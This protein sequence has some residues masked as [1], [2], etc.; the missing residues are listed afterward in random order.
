MHNFTNCSSISSPHAH[1][2]RWCCRNPN[3][4]CS[5]WLFNNHPHRPVE[6]KW[7]SDSNQ[8]TSDW[9]ESLH[10]TT[11]CFPSSLSLPPHLRHVPLSSFNPISPTHLPSHPSPFPPLSLPTPLP[12]H[13][14]HLSSSLLQVPPRPPGIVAVRYRINYR[15]DGDTFT[16]ARFVF[17]RFQQLNASTLNTTITFLQR[18]TEYSIQ[19][20]MEA[21]YSA[22]FSYLP[23]NFSEPILASTNA[24]G[25]EAYVF[26][27]CL[28][29]LVPIS[30]LSC[31]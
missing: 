28:T 9:P 10:T 1:N 16:R 4:C 17:P 21:R 26:D 5:C 15:S 12:S 23:G 24:T 27:V 2:F 11:V 30:P 22:C 29:P 18:N 6:C 20:R 19:V 7:P 13:P 14:L 3:W 8:L 31:L 25:E